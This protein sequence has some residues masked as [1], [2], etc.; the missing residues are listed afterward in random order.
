MRYK[1]S[2]NGTFGIM[3]YQVTNLPL[4]T[5]AS[6]ESKSARKKAASAHC[7][8]AELKGVA[9]TIPNE[10]ILIN[11][12]T[13]QEAKD[14]S[15]VENIVI[16]QDDLY[17]AGLFAGYT[18]PAANE[19]QDYATALTRGFDEIRKQKLIRLNDVLRVQEALEHNRAGR[20][21]RNP[22]DRNKIFRPTGTT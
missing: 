21:W 19:V 3:K 16:T 14:S 11:T 10:V 5:A 22:S 1:T 8:L 20:P 4:A 6:L 15:E 12:L 18:N 9:A 13:L 17:K 2:I 7:Y